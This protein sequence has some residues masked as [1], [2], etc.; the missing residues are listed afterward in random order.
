[1]EYD[2]VKNLVLCIK[3]YLLVLVIRRFCDDNFK[4]FFNIVLFLIGWVID[5]VIGFLLSVKR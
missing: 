1:M 4:F 5:Y 3:S 2:L